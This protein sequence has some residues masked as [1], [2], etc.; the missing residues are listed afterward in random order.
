M[1]Y[2]L[3]PAFISRGAIE[4]SYA[5]LCANW[6]QQTVFTKYCSDVG[7]FERIVSDKCSVDW[8]VCSSYAMNGIV[9]C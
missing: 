9:I 5:G 3:I 2:A 7:L 1:P 6:D 4:A 8:C